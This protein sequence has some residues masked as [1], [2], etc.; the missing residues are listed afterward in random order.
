MAYITG[1]EIYTNNNTSSEVLKLPPSVQYDVAA[2]AIMGYSTMTLSSV[3]GDSSGAWVQKIDESGASNPS[4][5]YTQVQG[6][7]PD[8]SVTVTYTAAE[9][10][11]YH[12]I[13]VRDCDNTTPLDVTPTT[14]STAVSYDIPLPTL[15]TTNNDCLI[16]RVASARSYPIFCDTGL[17][18]I[19]SAEIGSG[20]VF[21][22]SGYTYQETA[23][24]IGAET[25]IHAAANASTY[26]GTRFSIAFRNATSGESDA[27]LDQSVS[28]YEIIITL[29][30]W[31]GP[32]TFGA[33]YDPLNVSNENISSMTN[34]TYSNSN[35]Y[36]FSAPS[37]D[38]GPIERGWRSI[39]S[40]VTSTYADYCLLTGYPVT[41]TAG[42]SV[43]IDLSGA[44]LCISNKASDPRNAIDEEVGC[45]I[46]FSDKS[47]NFDFYQLGTSDSRPSLNSV[48]PSLIDLDDTTFRMQAGGTFNPAS[49]AGIIV[50][51]QPK[52]YYV[53]TYFSPLF[54]L[55]SFEMQGGTSGRP[56]SFETYYAYSSNNMLN[57]VLKQGG[58][59]EN[60]FFTCQE[61]SYG[62]TA[63]V[64]DFSNQS[65]EW[66][67]EY[68]SD[69]KKRNFKIAAGRLNAHTIDPVA[70]S[71]VTYPNASFNFGNKHKLDINTAVTVTM[72]G[73]K[74]L[75]ADVTVTAY[76]GNLTGPSFVGCSEI[77]HNS[78]S[79]SGGCS[80]DTCYDTNVI[81]YTGA[82][83]AALQTLIDNVANCTFTNNTTAVRVE[84]TGTGDVTLNFDNISWS[85]NTTDIHYDST[86][87]SALTANMQ[88]GSNASSS[89]ISGSATSVTIS[90]DIT[91][92]VAVNITGAEITMLLTG[93]Q[94]EEYHVETGTTS[95]GHTY[96]YSS[97]T[98]ID[99]QVFKAG[100]KPY[101]LAGIVLG[102][103]N[104]TITVNLDE[105]P[106]SQL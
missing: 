9:Y 90:N 34:G 57:T 42:S 29:S 101:W 85:G 2:I 37:H 83:Q 64:A 8:V 68:D 106:A 14:S 81:T 80:F 1:S 89:A 23:G 4:W 84:F 102:N 88:N 86:N 91:A 60:Q 71:I 12:V 95:Q 61:T 98:T 46:G 31:D 18:M 19:G 22:V 51:S 97:D 50:C 59:A 3:V 94:T 36:N 48:F 32:K 33:N 15:T 79:F 49:V 17:A 45:C 96:T 66:P 21:A 82:T 41:A 63:V 70:G 39:R 43:N 40:F 103:A 73:F 72:S 74:I 99:L 30:R 100:Y 92:T 10:A 58:L 78:N 11:V 62:S 27:Y 24:A 44:L 25:W 26:H 93:T 105:D 56:G 104:Q 77:V 38:V 20:V 35:L 67:S 13:N 55:G 16:W 28:L 87:S 69:V 52:A 6:A 53:Y 76:T 47:T 65:V 7:T 54:K 5:L 75:N